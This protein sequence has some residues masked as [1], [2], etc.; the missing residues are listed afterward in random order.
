MFSPAYSAG[1]VAV[2]CG[3]NDATQGVTLELY[4]AELSTIV[5]TILANGAALEV[6]VVHSPP[7]WRGNA[8]ELRAAQRGIDLGICAGDE[9]IRCSADLSWMVGREY[10]QADAV[11]LSALGHEAVARAV[12]EPGTWVLVVGLVAMGAGGRSGDE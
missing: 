9:R 11:H 3:G 1:K 7:S 8:S 4:E 2:Q 5:H 12:P 6:V 10:F